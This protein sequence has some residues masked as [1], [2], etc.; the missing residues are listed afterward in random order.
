M[1]I[2]RFAHPLHCRRPHRPHRPRRAGHVPAARGLVT[3]GMA[4]VM[5]TA[6]AL[7]AAESGSAGPGSDAAGVAVHHA[8]DTSYLTVGA[9]A[10][11]RTA[12]PIDT[13]A[14]TALGTVR[15]R[16]SCAQLASR[17][18]SQIS[19]APTTILSATQVRLPATSRSLRPPPTRTITDGPDIRS[20]P[21]TSSGASSGGTPRP[22]CASA[23][24]SE[25]DVKPGRTDQTESS[26]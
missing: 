18:F 17:D 25:A 8:S 16:Y 9:T 5:G 21:D 2:R 13:Q 12:A 24:A 6:V 14:L 3:L 7:A 1:D 23:K 10:S 20:G 11:R 4:L 26:P 22:W 19:D 15:P